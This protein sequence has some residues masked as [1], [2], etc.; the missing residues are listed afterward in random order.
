MDILSFTPGTTQQ[1]NLFNNKKLK[2]VLTGITMQSDS[3]LN[4]RILKIGPY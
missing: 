1:H 2:N 4:T 3:F